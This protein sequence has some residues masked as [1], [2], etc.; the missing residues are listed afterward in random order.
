MQKSR[1]VGNKKRKRKE[2]VSGSRRESKED[3]NF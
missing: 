2:K 3:E 1:Y